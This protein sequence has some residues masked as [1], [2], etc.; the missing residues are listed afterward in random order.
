MTACA[1]FTCA[2]NKELKSKISEMQSMARKEKEIE[3]ERIEVDGRIQRD[4]EESRPQWERAVDG[5]NEN[6]LAL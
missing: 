4:F 6:S 5:F 2:V 3:S 1:M